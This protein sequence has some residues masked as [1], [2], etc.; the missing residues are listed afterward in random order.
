MTEFTLTSEQE[1]CQDIVADWLKTQSKP[2]LT[3]HGPAGSG[4]SSL[5]ERFCSLQDGKICAATFSGKAAS[6]LR[7]KGFPQAKT[8][9]SLIYA[10]LAERDEELI[11]LR[12][13]LEACSNPSEE[14]RLM[15]RIE[16]L[17]APKFTLKSPERCDLTGAS[18]LVLDECGMV[19]EELAKDLLSFGVPILVLGDPYQLPPIEGAGYFDS[20]ADFLLTEIH[21]QAKESPV[22][23]LATIAREGRSFRSGMYGDSE[24]TARARIDASRALGVSQILSGSN[25][26]REALNS[27]NRHLRG[28]S[29]SWP[30][31]GE[32]LICLRNNPSSGILN[33]E[34]IELSADAAEASETVVNIP[35]VERTY[36][37]YKI[38]F[39]DPTRLKAMPWTKRVAC[40]EFSF[41]YCITVHRA[42]GSQWESVL[43][44]DDLWAWNKEMQ[45]RSRYTALTRA[46]KRVVLAL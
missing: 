28:F 21:R 45:R 10:P 34:Q 6:V 16:D 23:Q 42:Q 15:R 11:E 2:W 18:L 35:T 3:I 26:A 32:R 31:K 37:C 41:A 24:V 12:V 8:I 40:D 17:S 43:V 1:R 30:K 4:K 7:K 25:K 36:R 38:C 20:K 13:K 46:E 5:A 9:H 27:E 19:N 22:I 33:G 44:W 29:G 39:T 14:R